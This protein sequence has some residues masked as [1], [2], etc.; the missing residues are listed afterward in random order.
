MCRR[1]NGYKESDRY[2]VLTD[3]NNV[4]EGMEFAD[5]IHYVSQRCLVIDADMDERA[6]STNWS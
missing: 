1:G 4:A 5:V 3:R 2:F 6:R